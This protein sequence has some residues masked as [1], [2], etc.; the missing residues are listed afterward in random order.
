MSL[1]MARGCARSCEWN[2]AWVIGHG[3]VPNDNLD[4]PPSVLGTN[5]QEQVG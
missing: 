5:G 2:R 4:P 1:S 3:Q